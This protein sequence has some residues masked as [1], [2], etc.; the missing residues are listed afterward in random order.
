MMILMLLPRWDEVCRNKRLRMDVM[1]V[2]KEK[3]GCYV[4]N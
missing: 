4:A 2:K 1:F 3:N